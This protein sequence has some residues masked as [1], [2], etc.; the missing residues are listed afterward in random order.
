MGGIPCRLFFACCRPNHGRC[1][2]LFQTVLP[3]PF[4][5]YLEE[6]GFVVKRGKHKKAPGDLTSRGLFVFPSAL[7]GESPSQGYS[8]I[9]KNKFSQVCSIYCTNCWLC[10][11][12]LIDI[13]QKMNHSSLLL[14]LQSFRGKRQQLIFSGF[15]GG[16]PPFGLGIGHTEGP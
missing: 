16:S 13:V 14:R 4:T 9:D 11:D 6:S 2:R 7:G 8:P 1:P 15:D 3:L 5:S 10:S 12:V